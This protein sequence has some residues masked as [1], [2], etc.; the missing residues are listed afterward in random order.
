MRDREGGGGQGGGV[1]GQRRREST[2]RGR[3]ARVSVRTHEKNP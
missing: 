2:G 3:D 1:S